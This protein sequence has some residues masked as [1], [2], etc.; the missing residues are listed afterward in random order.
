[1]YICRTNT[2]CNNNI[3]NNKNNNKNINGNKRKPNYAVAPSVS[4]V[5]DTKEF[6]PHGTAI[7]GSHKRVIRYNNFNYNYGQSRKNHKIHSKKKQI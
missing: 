3:N 4:S 2:V 6:S 7:G 1:M 5:D